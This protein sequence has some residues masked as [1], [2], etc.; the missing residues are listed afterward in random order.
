M[1]CELTCIYMRFC[2]STFVIENILEIDESVAD[3]QRTHKCK[4]YI[5]NQLTICFNVLLK[6]VIL[7]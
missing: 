3:M 2:G 1:S 5:F 4:Q 7:L 6:T